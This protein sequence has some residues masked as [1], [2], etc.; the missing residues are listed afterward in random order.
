MHKAVREE[1]EKKAGWADEE[2]DRELTPKEIAWWA[3]EKSRSKEQET[4]EA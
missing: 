2:W 4:S 1:G 3:R